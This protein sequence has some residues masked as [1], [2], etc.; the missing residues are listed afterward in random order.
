MLGF[1]YPERT[2]NV[3]GT[4]T[5]ISGTVINIEPR[6][7]VNYSIS[8]RIA[9]NGFA[10]GETQSAAYTLE[11]DN[12]EHKLKTSD[13]EG[14][15]VRCVI[16]MV[17]GISISIPVPFGVWQVTSANAL[18]QSV[19]ISM[20][21]GDALEFNFD[22]KFLKTDQT[23]A[24]NSNSTHGSLLQYVCDKAGV[25]LSTTEFLHSTAKLTGD[26][27]WPD[28]VTLRDVVSYIA[29]AAGGFARIARDGNL[30]IVGYG[31]T[32]NVGTI[33]PDTYITLDEGDGSA[34][35]FRRLSVKYVGE[36]NYAYYPITPLIA[37]SGNTLQV[38]DNPLFNYNI[39]VTVA[40]DLSAMKSEPTRM[41]W[42]GDPLLRLGDT[43]TIVDMSNNEREIIVN[44]QTIT[45][46]GGMYAVTQCQLPKR[47]EQSSGFK[48]THW[49][50]IVNKGDSSDDDMNL[51]PMPGVVTN[52]ISRSETQPLNAVYGDLWIVPSTG[53]TYQCSS[54]GSASASVPSFSLDADG[55]LL[56]EPGAD[57]SDLTMHINGDGDLVYD[58]VSYQM[59]IGDDGNI[60]IS[61]EA[62]W[63]EVYDIALNRRVDELLGRIQSGEASMSS[64][65]SGGNYS[66]TDVIFPHA[67]KADTIPVV[68]VGFRTSSDAAAFGNCACSAHSVS[69]TGFKIRFFNGDTTKRAP[70][71]NWIAVGRV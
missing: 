47:N 61:S 15:I 67:Y 44:S 52:T 70:G 33:T 66:D 60:T 34:F 69:A 7:I 54:V 68:V 3:T 53:K 1:N 37:K 29:A 27:K 10:L 24:A 19:T 51:Q 57:S 16:S 36:D 39:M 48:P 5:L 22:A 42:I 18:E 30:E 13:L 11:I 65:V 21:G 14:A 58:G 59:N 12:T 2:L 28:D 50:P 35:D 71:F 41:E 64:G 6:N 20:S 23:A 49:M 31:N 55:N 45:Y 26:E 56:Y 38:V 8:E 40:T 9:S 46:D 32:Q 63:D 62:S 25:T 17:R 4:I 43:V